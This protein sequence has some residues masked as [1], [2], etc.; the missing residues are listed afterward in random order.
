M[1]ENF[2]IMHYKKI[3]LFYCNIGSVTFKYLRGIEVCHP[4]C[5]FKLYGELNSVKNTAIKYGLM[6]VFISKEK[7]ACFGL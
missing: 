6:T 4:R 2:I 7:T 5:A 3:K 1:D